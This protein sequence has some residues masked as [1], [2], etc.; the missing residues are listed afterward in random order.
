MR[1]SGTK[2]NSINQY[3]GLGNQ[4]WDLGGSRP[5]LDLNFA[6][7]K[8][9]VDATTGQSLVTF[10]RASSG[11][12][13]GSDGVV[14]T[15]VTNLLLRSEEF[16][17][18]AWVKFNSTISTNTTTSPIG[19][20]TADSLVETSTNTTHVV[21]QD[22]STTRVGTYAYSIYLKANQRTRVQLILS[23]SGVN[24]V[25]A[26]FNLSAGAVISQA[27]SGTGSGVSATI[28]EVG[29]GWYRCTLAGSPANSLTAIRPHV[30]LLDS[31]NNQVYAGDG[32]SGIYL[33]GAQLEAG[34][35]PTS[36]IPTT[37]ATV[38]RAADVASITGSN[39]ASWYNASA[40]TI[41]SEAAS[42]FG[43]A[44]AGYLYTIGSNYNNSITFLRQNNFQPT[45]EVRAA[46]VS[47]YGPTGDA[48]TWTGTS[49]NKS[50]LAISP[51]SGRQASNG[52]LA[53]GGDDTS[54]S[55]PAVTSMTL[56]SLAGSFYFNGTIKRLVY[57]GQRLPNNVLQAIT[58]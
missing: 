31:A 39:F 42:S 11:T 55:I 33:W 48:A 27:N 14:K 29:S 17:N 6:D 2:T 51:T 40:S 36:Y 24:N 26:L 9:L 49:S 47:E 1:L 52:L 18:V 35:F 25:N 53:S 8:S 56:G 15:A 58:Q 38:T 32:T 5:S 4:L 34:A 23:D 12:Y 3:R 21:Y 37:S 50:A 22:Y 10:T 43:A 20:Q 19:T 45:G 46:S 16:D 7:S 30:Y 41:Y 13:V 44:V 54:I 57:W 28:Q